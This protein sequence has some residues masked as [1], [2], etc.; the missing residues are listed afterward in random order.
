MTMAGDQLFLNWHVAYSTQLDSPGLELK[1]KS[2]G[3]TYA[4]KNITDIWE[5]GI[6]FS[7]G[8]E[9]LRWWRLSWDRVGLT[10]SA[11][12]SGTFEGVGITFSSI[13][14]R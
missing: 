4:S 6:G 10:V 9:R 14:D 8:R 3:T 11:D 1:F 13:F 7:K 5:F 12:S 2:T